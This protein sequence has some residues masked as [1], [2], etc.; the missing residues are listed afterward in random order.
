MSADDVSVT[1]CY[2]DYRDL[3]VDEA[4][5]Q[6]SADAGDWS[7]FA[8]LVACNEED[9]GRVIIRQGEDIE[10]RISDALNATVPNLLQAVPDLVERRHVVIPY[11]QTYGYLR[12]D[13][14]ASDQLISG[15]HVETVRVKRA[16]LIPGI[17]ELGET[18]L[19]FLEH[20]ASERDDYAEFVADLRDDKLPAARKA[21]KG[22]DPES[23]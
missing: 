4:P 7:D 5:C 14:E 22:W 20:M 1:F 17:I 11:F 18:Y 19:D 6:S 23:G 15:D 2:L 12:L 8:E 10:V 3:D 13:P 16:G 9:M 21:V